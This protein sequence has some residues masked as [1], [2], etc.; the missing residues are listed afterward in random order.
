M[1]DQ[2]SNTQTGR[3]A[4]SDVNTEPVTN[5]SSNPEKIDADHSR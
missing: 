2:S 5:G 4:A 1:F 3:I